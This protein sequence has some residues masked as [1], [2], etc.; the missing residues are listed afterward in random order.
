MSKFKF[1]L[2]KIIL[3]IST[4]EKNIFFII[5]FACFFKGFTQKQKQKRPNFIVILTDDQ[6]WVLK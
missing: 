3:S 5:A 6:S 1:Y 4:F 2:M